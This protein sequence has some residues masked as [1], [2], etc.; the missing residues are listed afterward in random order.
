LAHSKSRTALSSILALVALAA[1]TLTSCSGG[2][3]TT[4]VTPTGGGTQSHHKIAI[5]MKIKISQTSKPSQGEKKSQS[6][7][8]SHTRQPKYVSPATNGVTVTEYAPG[9]TPPS[10]PTIAVNV[11][12]FSGNQCVVAYNNASRTC[13]VSFQAP[14]GVD[15]FAV[16]AYDQPPGSNGQIPSNANLLSAGTIGFTVLQGVVNTI[17]ITLGGQVATLA[18]QPSVILGVANGVPQTYQAYVE[19]LDADGYII[20]PAVGQSPYNNGDGANVSLAVTSGDPLG[21]LAIV[22]PASGTD[23]TL[24]TINYNGGSVSDAV[25]TGA[26][27]GVP[28]TTA[29]FTPL[30]TSP[31]SL[32]LGY[33]AAP[34]NQTAQVSAQTALST[35]TVY[36][37][38]ANSAPQCTVSPAS[39]TPI[40]PGASVSFTV[41]G[42]NSGTCSI[43]LTTETSSQQV[44]GSVPVTVN[45]TSYGL[46]LGG[47]KIKHIVVIIQE[48][49]SFDNI[50]GGLDNNGRPLPGA[51][52]VSNPSHNADDQT[53]PHD[54]YGNV[55][56]MQ[57]LAMG[58]PACYNPGHEHVNQVEDIDGGKMDGFN[59]DPPVQIAPCQSPTLPPPAPPDWVYQTIQYSDV[60]P[61]WQMA[62]QYAIA[63]HHFEQISSASFS[64]HLI[65]A[66]GTNGGEIDNPDIDTRNPGWGC[67][68][69]I[70]TTVT[71][72]FDQNQPNGGGQVGPFPCFNW[73]TFPDLMSARGVS[74]NWYAAAGPTKADLGYQWS[75]LNAFAQD[76][77]GPIWSNNVKDSNSF[78]TDVHA[79]NLAT[80]TYLTPY[81]LTSDHP[82]S[83]SNTG[84]P[85]IASIVNTIGNSQ[86]WPSTAIFLLWDDFGGMYDHVIPPNWGP[87]Q[88]P[89]TCL[90][91]DYGLRTGL[92]VVSP[93]AKKHYVFKSI[94]SSAMI[95]KFAEEVLNIPSLGGYDT[96]PNMA[97]L[98]GMFDF[99]QSPNF[100]Y[101]DI[102]TN[103]MTTKSL[104]KIRSTMKK[105]GPPD[106]Y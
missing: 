60:A 59:I 45:G 77:Y 90:C 69:P 93:W 62:E 106:D 44:T 82:R 33:T 54:S 19:P 13:T 87:S 17:E 42:A 63:D 76:R 29:N 83:G 1:T 65:L 40:Q 46:G 74:F 105:S 51:D 20:V 8:K 50:F 86:F 11:S 91:P 4:P 22:P 78:T 92:V 72:L 98:S 81:L 64:E 94:T 102:S 52:T 12:Q 85:F 48:N 67:D 41:A 56:Q 38:V 100:T 6:E 36:A 5:S 16:A 55:V 18:M 80:F 70:T 89:Q 39:A 96:D 73:P 9:Q 88:G 43:N 3:Q 75:S 34:H 35:A 25:L 68:D 24:Y 66:S 31:A 103:G 47:G 10:T 95:L 21:T 2:G 27:P 14:V 79:G 99:T 84:P 32:T 61:Y 58:V 71:Y 104:N 30:T 15:N 23:P 7:A 101:T 97:D 57:S 49:R 28:T 37:S 53:V 26:L